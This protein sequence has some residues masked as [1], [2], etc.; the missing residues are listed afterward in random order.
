MS[1][2]HFAPTERAA[3][4]LRAEQVP[5]EQIHITGN[6]VVDALLWT[7]QKPVDLDFGFNL[8]GK[9]TILVTAHRRESFGAPFRSLCHAILDLAERNEDV[10]VVYPVHLNPNVRKP[11]K[12]ILE[13]HARIHLLEPLRYEQ[14]SHLMSLSYLILTD[15][16]GLQEEAPVLGKPVLVMREITERPEAIEAG[17]AILVGTRRERIV[18]EAEKLLKD[19][20]SYQ[21]M[22]KAQSPF[23]DGHAAERIVA[24]LKSMA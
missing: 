17:T 21:R 1:T 22:A 3:E 16:G 24:I 15:S 4:A 18:A 12:Q 9:R 2:Y 5:D 7:L 19:E 8:D 14:F 6:T 10:A 13:G 23:G 11:V 20:D